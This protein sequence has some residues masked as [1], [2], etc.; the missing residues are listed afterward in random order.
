VKK[1]DWRVSLGLL[2]LGLF[3]TAGLPRFHPYSIA[4]ALTPFCIYF[5]Y[6]RFRL[7]P[8]TNKVVAGLAACFVG[9]LL[10]STVAIIPALDWKQ[11]WR[12]KRDGEGQREQKNVLPPGAWRVQKAGVGC[13]LQE[14]FLEIVRNFDRYDEASATVRM[15]NYLDKDICGRWCCVILYPGEIVYIREV[16]KWLHTV[17]LEREKDNGNYYS[18]QV[19]LDLNQ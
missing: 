11:P 7:N 12:I 6:H 3:L 2:I 4:M 19:L 16:D 14:T 15:Q 13:R 1:L 8:K 17:L 9:F 10:V 5:A 18:S